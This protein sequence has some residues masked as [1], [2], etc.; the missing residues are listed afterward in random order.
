MH[1]DQKWL[2]FLPSF[3]PENVLI[4]KNASINMAS[5]SIHEVEFKEVDE[6]YYVDEQPLLIFHF[7]WY[8]HFR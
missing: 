1:V 8:R 4:E 5:W 3:Y 2:D 7:F 6:I